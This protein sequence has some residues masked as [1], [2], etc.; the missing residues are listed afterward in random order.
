VKREAAPPPE[1]SPI[2]LDGKVEDDLSAAAV[3]FEILV[4][5]A[6]FSHRVDAIDNRADETARDQGQDMNGKSARGFR[7][8]FDRSRAQRRADGRDPLP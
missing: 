8:F 4:R 1:R 3:G 6:N 7:L 2:P 5:G